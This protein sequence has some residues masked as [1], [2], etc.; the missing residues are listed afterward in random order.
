MCPILL[1][2]AVSRIF[3]D[4]VANGRQPNFYIMYRAGGGLD[5]LHDKIGTIVNPRIPF[6]LGRSTSG[7]YRQGRHCLHQSRSALSGSASFMYGKLTPSKSH[8]LDGLAY[9]L[10][11]QWLTLV[12]VLPLLEAAMRVLRKCLVMPYQTHHPV[13]QFCLCRVKVLY[14]RLII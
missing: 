14:P 12:R 9:G 8:V 4:F 2:E 6:I 11:Y 13:R 3:S 7:I 10:H 1:A 5:I